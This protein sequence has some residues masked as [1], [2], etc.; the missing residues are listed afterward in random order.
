MLLI[1]PTTPLG[2]VI[3]YSAGSSDNLD[4]VREYA[5]SEISSREFCRIFKKDLALEFIVEKTTDVDIYFVELNANR[6]DEIYYF[7]RGNN[8]FHGEK[9]WSDYHQP[10]LW[11]FQHISPSH[12]I[13]QPCWFAGTR[14]N[15]THQLLDFLPNLLLREELN[16]SP[17]ISCR[18]NVFGKINS[19]V[20]SLNES[21]AINKALSRDKVLLNNHGFVHTIGI[22]NIRCI[23][24]RD[25]AI[26]KH[27]SIFKAYNL[28]DQ[29][30]SFITREIVKNQAHSIN[31]M[32]FLIRDD[33]RIENS[34]ELE[35]HLTSFYG[36]SIINP[37]AQLSY[38]EKSA[39]LKPFEVLVLPPGSDNINAYC[40][41]PKKTRFIQLTPISNQDILSSPFYSYA[42][43]RYSL[44][45][46]DRITLVPSIT[47]GS[48][49][50]NSGKWCTQDIDKAIIGATN[51]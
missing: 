12:I 44:P 26:P 15:Y 5:P 31:G 9:I 18:L 16:S 40:F 2:E 36:T 39:L 25:L 17:D 48:Q 35:A 38:A 27:I 37:M 50:L 43:I 28:L 22:W 19:I 20:D 42:G 33:G 24:F 45:F 3:E 29:A 46:L 14:N 32:A 30:F 11:A 51:A 21:P 49:G 34:S 8:F 10:F 13:E 7:K 1:G 47:T 41:A 6:D 23:R 4:Y